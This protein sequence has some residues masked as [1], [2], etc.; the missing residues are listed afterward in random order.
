MGGGPMGGGASRV[1]RAKAPP[2]VHEIALRLSDFYFGKTI[3]FKFERQK[4]CTGCSGLGCSNFVQCDHCGG[5][6]FTEQMMQIG[7]GMAAVSRG[8]CFTC[9]GEGRKPGTV[10]SG[11]NGRKFTSH[12]KTL[13]VQIKPG[14]KVGQTL[15]FE[16][17]CSDNPEYMEAGDVHIVLQEA[18]EDH[19]LKREG[20]HLHA[21]LTLNLVESLLGCEKVLK[22]HPAHPDG[23]KIAVSGGLTNGNVFSVEKKG[24]PNEKGEYGNLFCHVTV[25]IT[26]AEK[27]KLQNHYVMLKSML[28]CGEQTTQDSQQASTPDS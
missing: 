9:Q 10:C 15:V 16:R 20:D 14:M 6:G 3:Q 22:G 26:E 21:R 24:M 1:R 23:L 25:I 5:R 27:N 12:E 7:P 2:K 17:E 18:D 13:D 19:G 8:P 11:C 4:F 28:T